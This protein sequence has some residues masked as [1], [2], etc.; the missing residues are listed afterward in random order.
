MS[1][2]A[3]PNTDSVCSAI[4]FTPRI[5]AE[6]VRTSG[7]VEPLTF[8]IVVHDHLRR[9]TILVDPTALREA[10][11]I[12]VESRLQLSRAL[13]QLLGRERGLGHR[14]DDR[15]LNVVGARKAIDVPI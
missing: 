15:G 9:P 12:E 8:E 4:A 6:V 10:D 1:R 2:I 3:I 11:E 14:R 13:V 7:I 5:T